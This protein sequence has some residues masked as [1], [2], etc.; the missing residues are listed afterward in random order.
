MNSEQVLA[1]KRAEVMIAFSEG[2]EIE[3]MDRAN[4]WH[5]NTDP[6]WDWDSW[7]YRVKEEPLELWVN[8]Y[9][10][11]IYVHE[12]KEKALFFAGGNCIKTIRMVEADDK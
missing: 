11:D 9:E 1:K 2:K 12:T 3:F 6:S 10:D 7:D 5:K 4:K 8:V